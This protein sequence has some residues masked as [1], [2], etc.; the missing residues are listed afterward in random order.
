VVFIKFTTNARLPP[1]LRLKGEKSWG[2]VGMSRKQAYLLNAGLF[3]LAGLILFLR[4]NRDLV[5]GSIS[6]ALGGVMVLLA[7]MSDQT[8]P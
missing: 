4:P 8:K 7:L 3:F 1:R 5:L 6:L 2:G